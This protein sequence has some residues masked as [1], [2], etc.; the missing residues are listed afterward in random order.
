MSAPERCEGCT[1]LRQVGARLAWCGRVQ[2]T[3]RL[4]L[5]PC[6]KQGLRVQRYDAARPRRAGSGVT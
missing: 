2:S 4:A 5:G 1:Y 6:L 3:V